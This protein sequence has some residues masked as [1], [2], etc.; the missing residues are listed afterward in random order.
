MNLAASAVIESTSQGVSSAI[1]LGNNL[2]SR[3]V[4]ISL[5]VQIVQ[6]DGSQSIG[7]SKDGNQENQKTDFQHKN[8]VANAVVRESNLPTSAIGPLKSNTVQKDAGPAQTVVS[9]SV[10]AGGRGQQSQSK[11]IPAL[12][13]TG[14]SINENFAVRFGRSQKLSA[15]VLPD[16]KILVRINKSSTV[17]IIHLILLSLNTT[18]ARTRTYVR[19]YSY[20]RKETLHCCELVACKL[21]WRPQWR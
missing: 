17:V 10:P 7:S 16:A 15:K 9:P 12:V 5:P 14:M 19:T 13:P 11:G 6:G 1:N 21:L 2:Y 18:H 4:P 8:A 3:L 20:L